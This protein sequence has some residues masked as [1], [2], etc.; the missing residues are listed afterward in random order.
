MT[1]AKGHS[2]LYLAGQNQAPSLFSSST[3]L[4]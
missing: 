2:Q 4:V 1:A 3:D